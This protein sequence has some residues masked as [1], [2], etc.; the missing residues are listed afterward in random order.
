V[1]VLGGHAVPP[2]VDLEQWLKDLLEK[3]WDEADRDRDG[4]NGKG[5]GNGHG[6]KDDD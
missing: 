1:P 5:N 3:E 2:G 6:K 4:G